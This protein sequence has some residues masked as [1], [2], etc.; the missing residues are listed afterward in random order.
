MAAAVVLVSAVA[1]SLVNLLPRPEAGVPLEASPSLSASPVVSPSSQPTPTPTRTPAPSPKVKVP[2]S[3]LDC[4]DQLGDGTYCTPEPE[5]WGG[6]S[7]IYDSPLA[8]LRAACNET[9]V[10][11]TFA[12]GELKS[13][14]RRQSSLDKVPQVRKVCHPKV[15][16]KMLDEDDR[17]PDWEVYALAPQT[18]DEMF[19]RCIFGHGQRVGVFKLKPPP[20]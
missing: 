11:Q 6:V 16:N 15:V 13:M 7:N 2:G 4:S 1:I 20:D 18:E 17:R 5:C 14:P 3:F 12:A 9:H 8:G 10:Y 19:Y